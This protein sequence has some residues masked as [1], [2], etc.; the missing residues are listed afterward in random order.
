M[1]PVLSPFTW[2]YNLT[3]FFFFFANTCV[4]AHQINYSLNCHNEL[5]KQFMP[6][7]SRFI[8]K[9]F[10]RCQRHLFIIAWTV[11]DSSDCLQ[12]ILSSFDSTTADTLSHQRE[13]FH[14]FF[15]WKFNI[16]NTCRPANILHWLFFSFISQETWS[17]KFIRQRFMTAQKLTWVASNGKRTSCDF[18]FL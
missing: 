2:W 11:H 10:S 5:P 1:T 12:D 6:I 4:S 17:Y 8:I 14:K 16:H 9:T 3:I 13:N 15:Y 18:F 7:S